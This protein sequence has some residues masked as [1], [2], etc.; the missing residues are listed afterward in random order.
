MDSSVFE[1]LPM[2]FAGYLK[3]YLGFIQMGDD[4][5]AIQQKHILQGFL[6]R[7]QQ[8]LK[9]PPIIDPCLRPTIIPAFT[10]TLSTFE[11]SHRCLFSR[12]IND[13]RLITQYCFAYLY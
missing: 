11:I 4:E 6:V 8:A 13:P 9:L 10:R 5:R 1:N 7:S 3:Y 12:K 2:I